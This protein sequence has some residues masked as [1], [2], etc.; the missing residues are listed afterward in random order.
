MVAENPRDYSAIL[1][2]GCIALLSNRHGEAQKWL[3]KAIIL[4]PGG[5]DAKVMLAEVFYCRDDFQKAAAALNGVD[6]RSNELIVSQYPTLNVRKLASLRSEPP[7]RC[8]AMGK[9]LV[10]TGKDRSAAVGQGA[11]KRGRRGHFLHRY[12]G[13]GGCARHGVW[14]GARPPAIRGGARHLFR[15]PARRG[16]AG[17]GRIESLTLGDWRGGTS[18]GRDA[19]AAP[20][21]REPRGQACRRHH[22]DHSV[23]PFPRDLRLSPR[24]TLAAPEEPKSLAQFA[25]APGEKVAV[26]FWMASDHFMVG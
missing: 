10:E 25:A 5:A 13:L 26:P 1:Q 23:L 2:L 24:R 9:A 17:A 6:V 21:L 16:P 7:M 19:T 15:W 3:G 22:R 12:R 20:A 11:R 14:P 18:A 8:A 4:Q